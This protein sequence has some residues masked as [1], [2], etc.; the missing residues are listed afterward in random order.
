MANIYEFAVR[1]DIVEKLVADTGLSLGTDALGNIV[2]NLMS[3][4]DRPNTFQKVSMNG[5]PG[6]CIRV[7]QIQTERFQ[8]QGLHV[9]IHSGSEGFLDMLELDKN[10]KNSLERQGIIFTDRTQVTT[11]G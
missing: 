5:K 3:I 6:F 7:G 9:F 4:V 10:L 2:E 11:K 8:G 1:R